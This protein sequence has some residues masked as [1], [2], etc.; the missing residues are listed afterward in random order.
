MMGCNDEKLRRSIGVW[1]I[2]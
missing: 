1:E 2:G